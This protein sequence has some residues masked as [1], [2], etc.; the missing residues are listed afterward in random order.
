LTLAQG[1]QEKAEVISA[2]RQLSVASYKIKDF[3]CIGMAN[4]SL[5]N[6]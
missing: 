1:K 6:S 5:T 4:S 3:D 2:S